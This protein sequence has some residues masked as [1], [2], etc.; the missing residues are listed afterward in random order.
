LLPVIEHQDEIIDNNINHNYE[1]LKSSKSDRH[2]LKQ[3]DSSDIQVAK[4]LKYV[5]LQ[6]IKLLFIY[7]L[8]S[9]LIVWFFGASIYDRIHYL[10]GGYCKNHSEFKY[11][12]SCIVHGYQY[13][14]GFKPSG[15]S[16]I[17]STFASSLAF[18]IKS[19]NC[20]LTYINSFNPL[21]L[22]VNKISSIM[23]AFALFIYT[24]WLIMFTV[25]CLFYHTLIERVVGTL[26]GCLIV[27]LVYVK[28]KL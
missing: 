11:Y 21:S 25:T 8:I 9:I 28:F 17:T 12:R 5:Y 13:L 19:L 2:L 10:S 24:C 26:S 23:I 27:F 22:K 18:E 4:P 20:W 16:L 7:V 1:F 15:H 6:M 3:F 14:N